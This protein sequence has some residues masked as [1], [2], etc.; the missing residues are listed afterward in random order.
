[1]LKLFVFLAILELGLSFMSS[2]KNPN[3]E[4]CSSKEPRDVD[5]D[6][7]CDSPEFFSPTVIDKCETKIG[8]GVIDR[9]NKYYEWESE[10]C[11]VEC[12]FNETWLGYG[13][14]L[15]QDKVKTFLLNA[16]NSDEP[17]NKMIGATVDK[18]FKSSK[19]FMA[20]ELH[21]SMRGCSHC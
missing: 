1:M 12:V 4:L 9:N 13:S 6:N 2:N 17:W 16:T 15:T 11:V 20:K 19:N 3:K 14:Q 5:P 7:C 18:C 10:L 8:V 21:R